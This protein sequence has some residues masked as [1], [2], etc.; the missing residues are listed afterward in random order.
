MAAWGEMGSGE[1]ALLTLV[2]PH[3]QLELKKTLLDRMVHLL[4]RGYVLPVVSYIRKCLEKLDTDISLIRHFVTEVGALA[5][6]SG[7]DVTLHLTVVLV[8]TVLWILVRQA[9]PIYR[10]CYSFMSPAHLHVGFWGGLQEEEGGSGD[11]GGGP[12]MLL[13]SDQLT[14]CAPHRYWMSSRPPTPLTLCSF[15]CPSWKTTALPAPCK[16]RVNMTL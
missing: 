4:S 13:P 16:G 14:G 1:M 6:P 3:P 7:L 2:A 5:A 15:S 12:S 10:S 11:R 9:P 8:M